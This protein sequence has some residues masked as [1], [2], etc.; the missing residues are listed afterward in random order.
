MAQQENDKLLPLEN[1][2]NIKDEL[3]ISKVIQYF[4]NCGYEVP[5]T[6]IQNYVRESVVSSLEKGRYYSKKNI[7]EIYM[8]LYLKDI[9]TLKDITKINKKIF[10]FTNDFNEV[11]NIFFDIVNNYEMINEEVDITTDNIKFIYKVVKSKKSK[12]EVLKDI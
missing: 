7:V 1:L 3:A 8:A 12:L 11:Y 6:T 9:F 2:L 5:K 4:S 10:S